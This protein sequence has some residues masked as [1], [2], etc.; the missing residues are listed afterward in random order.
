LLDQTT[1]EDLFRVSVDSGFACSTSRLLHTRLVITIISWRYIAFS[2]TLLA[3]LTKTVVNAN[4]M[5]VMYQSIDELEEDSFAL[6]RLGIHRGP[7]NVWVMRTAPRLEASAGQQV[8]V[9]E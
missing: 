6:A 1:K 2:N 5:S 7:E 4:E 8:K 3:A 9:N